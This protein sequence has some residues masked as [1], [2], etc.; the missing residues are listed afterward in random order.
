MTII[1]GFQRPGDFTHYATLDILQL[2]R[3][4]EWFINITRNKRRQTKKQKKIIVEYFHITYIDVSLKS[5]V[6]F[7]SHFVG[8]NLCIPLA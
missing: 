2:E 7:V 6:S 8:W 5:A 1:E 4:Y 3:K